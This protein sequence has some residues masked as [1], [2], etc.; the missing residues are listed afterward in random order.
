MPGEPS[1]VAP[2]TTFNTELKFDHDSDAFQQGGT[3]AFTLSSRG[4][5]LNGVGKFIRL[6]EPV[7]VSFSAD[8]VEH[9]DSSALDA[10]KLNVYLFV[11]FQDWDN[12]GTPKVVYKNTLFDAV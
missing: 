1:I 7:A 3:H 11:Y 8:F 4:R 2:I 6:N 10:T 12:A 9:P 5:N